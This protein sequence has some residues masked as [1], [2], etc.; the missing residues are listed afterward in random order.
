[1]NNSTKFCQVCGQENWADEEYCYYCGNPLPKDLKQP[2]NK[3]TRTLILVTLVLAVLFLSLL[4]FSTCEVLPSFSQAKKGGTWG[5][6]GLWSKPDVGGW[7]KYSYNK[8][9]EKGVLEV[10]V[11]ERREYRG[12]EVFILQIVVIGEDVDI[13]QFWIPWSGANMSVRTIHQRGDETPVEYPIYHLGY[14]I[15][16][17]DILIPPGMVVS[18]PNTTKI[19]GWEQLETGAGRF[20]TFHFETQ[21][22]GEKL[23]VWVSEKVPVTRM[24]RLKKQSSGFEM[25]LVSYGRRGA[26]NLVKKTPVMKQVTPW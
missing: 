26:K 12:L 11:P 25:E 23:E 21:L 6:K 7:V 22:R 14:P 16:N 10:S 5:V 24:V 13:L 15:P 20:E 2:I 8:K 1:M 18:P 3:R 17:V 19:F 4:I 9:G